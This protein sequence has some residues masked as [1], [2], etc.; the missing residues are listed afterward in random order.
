MPDRI[1]HV[2]YHIPPPCFPTGHSLALLLSGA[3]VGTSLLFLPSLKEE[4]EEILPRCEFCGSDLRPFLSSVD[5]DS[6]N[7]SSQP[8]GHVSSKAGLLGNNVIFKYHF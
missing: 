7:S 8:I 6:D 1:P 2:G 4:E 3:L 5:V